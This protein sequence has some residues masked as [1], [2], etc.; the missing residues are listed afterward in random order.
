MDTRPKGIDDGYFKGTYAE[1]NWAKLP[2]DVRFVLPVFGSGLW[3]EPD[4]SQHAATLGQL[5]RYWSSWFFPYAHLPYTQVDK[6]IAL[7][8]SDH[9]PLWIDYERSKKYGTIPSATLLLNMCRRVEDVTGEA[10]GIYSR[11]ELVDSHL[12]TMSTEDLNARWWWLAQYV[13]DSTVEDTRDIILPLRVKRERI[14]IHQT[15]D[16]VA[17]YPGFYTHVPTPRYMDT[18][19]WIGK[20]T[21]DNFAGNPNPP[22]PP[23]LEQRVAALEALHVGPHGS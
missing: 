9:F 2:A 18:D 23:T 13:G 16:H 17:P 19:R 8:R 4:A 22:V 12:A 7:P 6:W 21:I 15:A 10:C 14:L 1:H 20:V 11:K 5:N 3:L